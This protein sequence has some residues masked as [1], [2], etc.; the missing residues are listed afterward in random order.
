MKLM[1]GETAEVTIVSIAAGGDG[2]ARLD[3][4]V[5]FIPRAAPGDRLRVSMQPRKG[6]ARA[7]VESILSPSAAR[8]DPPC[9]HYREDDCGGCQIQHLSAQAQLAAKSV[10]V[11]DGV[12][13][14]GRRQLEIPEVIPSPRQWRYRTRLTLAF[15]RAGD[16]LI[17]GLH[18]YN[19][20][21]GVFRLD[22]CPIT[23]DVVIE[24]W[25]RI[26]RA[27]N[28]LPQRARRGTVRLEPGSGRLTAVIEGGDNWD[29][30]TELFNAVGSL[31]ALGWKPERGRRRLMASRDHARST[32]IAPFTQVN[33]EMASQLH[34]EVV[35][36]ALSFRP[37]RVVDAYAGTGDT[38]EP[39][40]AAGVSVTAIEHDEEAARICA[41]RMS[42]P[43]SVITARVED[44]LAG[45]LPADV[46]LLNPPRTGLDASITAILENAR[47]RPRILYVSCNPATLGRD[48]ARL[49]GY[50]V[51]R[52]L[53]FDMFPQTAH[54][55]TL[56]ELAPSPE[57]T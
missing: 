20:P 52:V 13:R 55:E 15:A 37:K 33:P 6:F 14:L 35:A 34:G 5:V 29:S 28:H 18:P 30:A 49:P 7:Q 2:V 22:D 43:S 36:R 26:M 9:R 44:V 16:G 11:R 41:S 38:A 27:S 4:M 10:I 45:A 12:V 1:G 21:V 25:R 48:I 53:A 47:P 40:A 56:C 8:V 51:H 46:V 42:P 24:T 31:A 23:E 57:A 54:V 32:P 50:S 3:G 17:A 39:L 19:D